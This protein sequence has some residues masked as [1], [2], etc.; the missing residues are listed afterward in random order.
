MYL[1]EIVYKEKQQFNLIMEQFVKHG[2]ES[3][4][5]Q[6]RYILTGDFIFKLILEWWM[7]G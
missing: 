3:D 7:M 2:I 5:T 4:G 1:I 6:T